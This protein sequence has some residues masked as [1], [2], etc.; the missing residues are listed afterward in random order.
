MTDNSTASE[1]KYEVYEYCGPDV[2][3]E[4][5][6]PFPERPLTYS[7]AM[8]YAKRAR[9]SGQPAEIHDDKTIVWREGSVEDYDISYKGQKARALG[10]EF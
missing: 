7:E 9:A 2:G 5:A 10:Y 4:N 3:W 8:E 6:G 1:K